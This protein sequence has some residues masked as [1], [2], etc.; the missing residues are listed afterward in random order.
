LGGVVARVDDDAT[1][2]TG[3]GAAH[4]INFVASWLPDDPEPERHKAWA[5]TAWDAMRPH[6]QGVYVNFMSDEPASHVQIAYGES[7]YARLVALKNKYDPTNV[8][9]FNQN[10]APA[11]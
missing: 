7:K 9:R 2:F 8:F 10:I 3:R 4:D 5:R 1:A 11:D 6:A